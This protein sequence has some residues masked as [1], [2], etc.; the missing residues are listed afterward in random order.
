MAAPK[1]EV[2]VQE[3]EVKETKKAE[4]WIVKVVSNPNYCGVGAG[5][6][7]FANGQART[8]SKRMADWFKEH[9]GYEVTAE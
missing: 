1:K 5:G 8:E 9:P 7:Q 6:V 3:T 4:A 2:E